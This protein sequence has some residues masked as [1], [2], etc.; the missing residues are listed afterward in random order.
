MQ[1]A[2]RLLFRAGPRLLSDSSNSHTHGVIAK[3]R[4]MKNHAP[5]EVYPLFFACGFMLT[6]MFS[7]G[8]HKLVTDRNLRRARSIRT[9]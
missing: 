8:I 9:E 5:P 2:T 7:T 3:L 4:N 1:P 6:V